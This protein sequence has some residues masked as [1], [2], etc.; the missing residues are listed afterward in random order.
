MS[1]R[2]TLPKIGVNMTEAVISKWLVKP[3]DVIKEG[4]PVIEAETDK[5]TQ[6]IYA[7]EGGKIA[8]LLAEEGETVQCHADI[9]VLIDEGEEYVKEEKAE[10]AKPEKEAAAAPEEKAAEPPKNVSAPVKVQGD[11]VRIS[12]LA[13]KIAK[14]NGIDINVLAG[15][16]PNKRIVKNDVNE[17]ISRNASA[18]RAVKADETV[19]MSNVRKIIAR[20]MTE[21]SRDIPTVPLV[22]SINAAR[23][24]ELRE[25]YKDKGIKVSYDAI[26]AKAAGKALAEH[27]NINVSY[28]GD[29]MIVHSSCNVGVAVDTDKGLFVPVV[30]DAAARSLS[31]I[32]ADLS[33][34]VGKAKEGRL[35]PDDSGGASMTIT[36]LGMFGVEEFT[37]I[38]NPPESCILGI[39]GFKNELVPDDEDDI[40]S[41]PTMKLTLVFDHRVV[42]GAPAARFLKTI[43]EYLETPELMI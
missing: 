17:Y 40:V 6:E 15:F 42:D 11:R 1:R 23:L 39:G 36:N 34:K 29:N 18:P 24:I 25:I 13:R 30:R 26:I 38:I 21:S 3:G 35:S 43:A 32:G 14:E 2:M 4:D 27:P 37:P 9:I 7:T 19:A 41:I 22:T 28:A 33:E 31:E 12:P 5:S 10:T 20:K 16:Y 8:E